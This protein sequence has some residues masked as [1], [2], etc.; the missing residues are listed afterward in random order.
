MCLQLQRVHSNNNSDMRPKKKQR[1]RK[2][3]H[4]DMVRARFKQRI[5]K[6]RRRDLRAQ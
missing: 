3:P 6:K 5:A 4:P 1:S 2:Q